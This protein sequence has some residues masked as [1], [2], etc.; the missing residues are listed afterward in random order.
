MLFFTAASVLEANMYSNTTH[1]RTHAHNDLSY[2]VLQAGSK[3]KPFIGE[4]E[5]LITFNQQSRGVPWMQFAVPTWDF[6]E[7]CNL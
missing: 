5:N 2:Q 1:A 4:K 3:K 6:P 7:M